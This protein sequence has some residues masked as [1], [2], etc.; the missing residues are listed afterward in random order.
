MQ[1]DADGQPLFLSDEATGANPWSLDREETRFSPEH[2]PLA[3]STLL[4]TVAVR[5]AAFVLMG[6]ALSLYFGNEDWAIVGL[7]IGLLV[8]RAVIGVAVSLMLDLSTATRSAYESRKAAALLFLWVFEMGFGSF[9]R[10]EVTA[11][12]AWLGL[13]LA[14]GMYVYFYIRAEQVVYR[15][16]QRVKEA[17][18]I[19]R[20][21]QTA[22]EADDEPP[23]RTPPRRPTKN[24]SPRRRTPPT[25]SG[26]TR[27]RQR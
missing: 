15:Y 18:R 27:P 14:A 3:E 16:K 26:G 22:V 8:L 24:R 10:V 2:D 21:T 23:R 5:E 9:I 13:L 20:T 19:A 25:P 6:C 4:A 11:P 12:L 7:P 17:E 1:R